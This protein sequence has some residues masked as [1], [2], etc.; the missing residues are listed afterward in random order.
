MRKLIYFLLVLVSTPAISQDMLVRPDELQ[1]NSDF[2]KA[3]FDAHFNDK[4]DNYLALFMA[5]NPEMTPEAYAAYNLRYTTHLKEIDRDK[6][7]KKKA[8]KK[9]KAIYDDI[10]GTFL[11]KYELQNDFS[12][13]FSKGYY[14][15]VSASALYGLAFADLGIPFTIKEKPTHVYVVAYPDTERILVESTDPTGGFITFSDHYKAAF[16]NQ[17]KQSKLI[18]PEEYKAKTTSQL[19]DQYYFSDQEVSLEEL[20]GIQYTNDALYKLEEDEKEKAY[21]Q[22]EKAYLF[23]PSDKVITLL[24]AVCADIIQNADYPDLQHVEYLARLSRFKDYGISN[25]VIIGEFGRIN[26]IFLVDHGDVAT[27]DKYYQHLIS[28]IQDKP[29]ITEISYFYYYERGRTLYNQGRYSDALPFFEKAYELKPD[30]LEANNAFV[31]GLGQSLR[32]ES[33]NSTIISQLEDYKSKHPRLMDNNLFKSMLVSAYLIQCGQSFDLGKAQE[34]VS[35][36]GLFEKYYSKDL[37]IDAI[38][39][40]RVYSLAAVYYFRKGYTAKAKNIIAKGL[41]Y[42]P[43]NHE[44]LVRQQMIR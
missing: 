4:K 8:E 16:V 36:Q 7:D 41:E 12:R 26:S 35:Y 38:N 23:Y 42:A 25:D 37:N 15:C 19:F 14:N 9:I 40:G 10:H 2:E 44:L 34:A 24:V 11:T 33:N 13:I 1:F 17:M 32:Y 39:I 31:S 29:L 28:S 5:V 22:L 3:A 6:L 21:Q 18:G 20:I 27:Y 30:N 43:G